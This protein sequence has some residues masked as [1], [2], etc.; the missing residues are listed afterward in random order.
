[1]GETIID[2]GNRRDFGTGA[3]RD[4]ADG[5]GRMDLVP[6]EV[7]GDIIDDEIIKELGFYIKDGNVIRLKSIIRWFSN[8]NLGGYYSSL[9][10]LSQHYEAGCQKYGDRNWEKGIPLHCYIDSATRHYAKFMR[11]DKD[12]CHDRAFLWNIVGAIWT[13]KNKPEL[14]DLPFK[15]GL[16]K[17]K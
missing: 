16:S 7:F 17:E 12:E 6:L 13:Q 5:K 9:I 4:V 1:M 8:K 14:I 3:V 2:S 15:D 11:G 10:A